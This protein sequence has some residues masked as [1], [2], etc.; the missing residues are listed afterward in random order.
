MEELR[1]KICGAPLETDGTKS[2]VKCKYCGNSNIVATTEETNEINDA[3]FLLRQGNF[4]DADEKFQDI[5]SR[6]PKSSEAYYGRVLCKYGIVYVD[7]ALENKKV[8]TIYNLNIKSFIDDPLFKKALDYANEETKK[9]YLA[10]AEK[11]EAIRKEWVEKANKEK[12]YDV[13]ICF[14][15]S[16]REAGIQR[17]EDSIAATDIYHYLKDQGLNVFFSRETLRGK[18]S[19]K[20]E[21]YI[22]NAL[23]TAPVML[24][25]T[26]KKEYVESTWV[27]N[28]WM[29]FVK[30]IKNKEKT[31]KGLIVAYENMDP[32]DL[33]KALVDG[34]QAM[35][36]SSKTFLPDLIKHINEVI[37]EVRTPLSQVETIEIKKE[38]IVK[39]K[40]I[41]Q[42]SVVLEELGKGVITNV[43]ADE[44]LKKKSAERYLKNQMYSDARDIYDELINEHPNN[45]EYVMGR[46][47][48]LN[49]VQ[50]ISDLSKE[51]GVVKYLP[52][53]EKAITTVSKDTALDYLNLCDS[54]CREAMKDGTLNEA[55][56][57]YKFVIK[58]NYPGNKRLVKDVI[59]FAVYDK[60]KSKKTKINTT[61]GI[62]KLKLN[63][64]KEAIVA[65]NPN[66]V[67]MHL[68]YRLDMING[69][70]EAGLL[71][72]AK[73]IV[74]EIDEIDKGNVDNFFNK[75]LINAKCKTIHEFSKESYLE[76]SDDIKN[77]LEE[78]ISYTEDEADHIRLIN[79]M[80]GLVTE[81][82]TI[83]NVKNRTEYFDKLIKYYPKSA[84]GLVHMNINQMAEKIITVGDFE[85]AS[86]YFALL[87]AY[88]EKDYNAYWGILKCKLQ[89]KTDDDLVY[90]LQPI[91]K[92]PEYTTATKY[93]AET[94]EEF[95]DK[96]FRIVKKQRDE[97]NRFN[98]EKNRLENEIDK[99]NKDIQ[100]QEID[101]AKKSKISS[102]KKKLSLTSVMIVLLVLLVVP[103]VLYFWTKYH[104]YSATIAIFLIPY[105]ALMIMAVFTIVGVAFVYFG[106]M[107]LFF[108][109]GKMAE[110][111]F[112]KSIFSEEFYTKKIDLRIFN[113]MIGTHTYAEMS[114]LLIIICFCVITIPLLCFTIIKLKEN[115]KFEINYA[116]DVKHKSMDTLK[117]LRDN[118]DK[119]VKELVRLKEKHNYVE[120]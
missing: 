23:N 3:M 65:Y 49:N 110:L 109:A 100:Y 24:V 31:F 71:E 2:V 56:N 6:Y 78:V 98:V 66:N 80:I 39:T 79:E 76:F 82:I 26:Q 87:T 69:L 1:C 63:L 119:L 44:N 72:E 58:Y 113:D 14:K 32:Y 70:L 75:L 53:I 91:D 92:V 29:R 118:K 112:M 105:V 48:A 88:D 107:L 9:D 62:V 45:G 95:F 57:F 12:P 34:R 38:K 103:V 43:S 104:I 30:K 15:D 64:F 28:E 47:L 19:E 20:F 7:D 117:M 50:S 81:N 33:P 17:T 67:D 40:E 59:E 111:P 99:F 96:C 85:V 68:R 84:S 52:E 18:V 10:S 41:K 8:P 83:K 86:K 97:I 94:N 13:F 37:K 108:I 106:Y 60:T 116:D 115:R 35:D 89:A 46:I 102:K 74:Q 25:Y 93:A 16:D 21:P 61:V 114:C 4:D 77:G 120:E 5:I 101:Y 90:S 11:I 42:K 36:A 22:F 73:E 55:Y 51:D 54:L 27:K